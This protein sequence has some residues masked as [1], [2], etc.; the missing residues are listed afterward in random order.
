MAVAPDPGSNR[1]LAALPDADWRRWLPH[2]EPVSLAVGQALSEPGHTPAH[3]FFPATAVVS[4]L[5]LSENGAADEVAVVGN[6]GVVGISL[7]LSGGPSIT[8]AVVQTSGMALRLAARTIE[9]EF[10]H[11]PAVMQLLLHY[12]LAL[13]SQMA[14]T[15]VCSRHHALEQRLCRRLL[16]G[17]RRQHGNELVMTQEQLAILLGMRRE[18]ITTVA[19]RLQQAGVVRYSRGHI[20]VL[21]REGLEQRACECRLVVEKEYERLLP[22]PPRFHAHLLASVQTPA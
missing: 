15:V 12:T 8:H 18:S 7:F 20:F 3:A 16:Q 1:L 5:C 6:E 11:S 2:L 19:L 4:L 17:L 21:D 13:S 10:L 14:Q 22:Q 9:D